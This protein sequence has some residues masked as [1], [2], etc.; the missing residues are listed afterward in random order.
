[1]TL[2]TTTEQCIP[3]IK[4]YVDIC[5]DYANNDIPYVLHTYASG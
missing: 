2:R 1:M 3:E 4:G 5:T